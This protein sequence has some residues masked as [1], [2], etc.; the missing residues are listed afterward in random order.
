MLNDSAD[1]KGPRIDSCIEQ[2]KM[3]KATGC[4]NFMHTLIPVKTQL[5]IDQWQKVLVDYWDRQILELI[6]FGFP[7]DFNR[8]CVL[9]CDR[10]NH[11]SAI[12]YPRHV[13]AYLTEEIHY[14]AI[15]GPFDEKPFESLHYSPFMTREKPN[16]ENKGIIVDLS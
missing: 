14:G 15:L 11:T 5:N 9:K 4:Q 13:E 16:S 12:D 1:Y 2:H 8:S 7:L 6:R 3:V 10:E